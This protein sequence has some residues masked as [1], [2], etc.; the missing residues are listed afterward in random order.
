MTSHHIQVVVWR[1][2]HAITQ[3]W[4]HLDELD[5]ED[6]VVTSV[7]IVL[8]DVKPGYLVLAQSMIDNDNTVDHALAIPVGMIVST[9]DIAV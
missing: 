4:T 8:H 6:C 3:T 7:G 9:V 2:A 5:K 1:D